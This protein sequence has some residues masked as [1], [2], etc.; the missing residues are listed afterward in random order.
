MTEPP[1]RREAERDNHETE[2]ARGRCLPSDPCPSCR[3]AL[4]QRRD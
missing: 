4:E 3:W 1:D 2:L